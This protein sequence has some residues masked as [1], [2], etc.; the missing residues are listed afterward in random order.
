MSQQSVS[1]GYQ[2]L[3]K[4]LSCDIV[5]KD[6][7]LTIMEPTRTNKERRRRMT[8]GE[9]S[10]PVMV[11]NKE[12]L[13]QYV[14]DDNT[15]GYPFMIYHPAH[16]ARDGKE[17][18]TLKRTIDLMRHNFNYKLWNITYY[19]AAVL[20][21]PKAQ[22]GLKAN[23]LKQLKPLASS[24]NG[25][26]GEFIEA[27]LKKFK[28]SKVSTLMLVPSKSIKTTHDGAPVEALYQ[29][30]S[31][32]LK[33]LEAAAAGKSK[34]VWGVAVPAKKHVDAFIKLLNHILPD[35]GVGGY[36]SSSVSR[37]APRFESVL[38]MFQAVTQRL[39]GLIRLYPELQEI[40]EGEDVKLTLA[41]FDWVDEFQNLSAAK[42]AFPLLHGNGLVESD[43]ETVKVSAIKDNKVEDTVTVKKNEKPTSE[44]DEL[45]AAAGVNTNPEPKV[46]LKTV[47]V[48][49][50]VGGEVIEADGQRYLLKDG[51]AFP[52][53]GA[54]SSGKPTMG[55]TTT[56]PA[57]MGGTQSPGGVVMM[58]GGNPNGGQT[59][60]ANPQTV[61]YIDGDGNLK[62]VPQMNV[63]R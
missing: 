24:F 41:K 44:M 33:E 34:T 8:M 56:G 18:F 5:E 54:A 51:K 61:T 39:D 16:E 58:G 57:V 25:K 59:M 2:D 35:L 47:G 30:N 10:L 36:D 46:G 52:I 62:T 9:D 50:D 23:Q 12:A 3:L 26:T 31:P 14:P 13:K 17:S 37:I 19:L 21:N 42:S 40:I 28:P 4:D 38:N 60:G 45:L 48:Q 15:G 32:L 53:S 6:G 43:K 27:V 1:L 63:M 49:K 22:D 7:L 55:G 20:S 29:L 11:P